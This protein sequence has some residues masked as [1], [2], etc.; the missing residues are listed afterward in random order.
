LAMQA[1]EIATGRTQM[2]DAVKDRMYWQR[3]GPWMRMMTMFIGQSTSY[4]RYWMSSI[5]ELMK[6]GGDKKKAAKVFALTQFVLPGL[7]QFIASGFKVPTDD[8][9]WWMSVLLG[10]ASGLFM[11]RDMA[12][13]GW[14]LASNKRQ[15]QPV[16]LA[17]VFSTLEEVRDFKRRVKSY[18]EKP[19]AEWFTDSTLWEV[20][21]SGGSVVGALVGV[22]FGPASRWVGGMIDSARGNTVAPVRRSLGFSE[23]KLDASK[24]D[25]LEIK[26]DIKEAGPGSPG[27]EQFKAMERRRT[28]LN[29]QL[30]SLRAGGADRTEVMQKKLEMQQ[31]HEDFVARWEFAY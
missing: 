7:F 11:V 1:F 10:P 27:Y 21:T 14:N 22:P 28:F 29:K 20:V 6:P 12:T 23:Y 4:Y 31:L 16:G 24:S 2:G 3:K 9:D 25:Y 17:P 26:R 18:M 5:L 13:F 30:E 15:W 19:T 8:D